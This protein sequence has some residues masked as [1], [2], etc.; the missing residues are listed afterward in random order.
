MD[1]NDTDL[2]YFCKN[3]WDKNFFN[4]EGGMGSPDQFSLFIALKNIK[5]KIIIESGVWNGISTKLIRKVC[6]KAIII[7]LDPRPLPDSGYKDSSEK[8]YTI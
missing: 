3:I 1:F 7:C 6:P 4:N 8:R 2:T 5:P